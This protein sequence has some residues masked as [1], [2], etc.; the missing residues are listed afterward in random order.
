MFGVLAL[1]LDYINASE[2]VEAANAWMVAKEE[3][4]GHLLVKNGVLNEEDRDFLELVLEKHVAKSGSIDQSLTELS[5]PKTNPIDMSWSINDTPDTSIDPG[6]TRYLSAEETASEPRYISLRPLAKGG[7][8]QVLIARDPELEREVALKEMLGGRVWSDD[9]KARFVAEAKITGGLEHPGIVPVYGLGVFSDGRP[10]YA[11]RLIRGESLRAAITDFHRRPTDEKKMHT[12]VHSFRKLI[13]SL[14]DACYAVAY[15]HNRGVI[16]RDLKPS[17]IMV[18]KFGETLVVDW[19]LAKPAGTSTRPATFYSE[20]PMEDV[21][22][23]DSAP[24]MMGSVLGTPSYM[25]PEQAEGRLDLMDQRTDVFSLGATLYVIL[26]NKLPYSS[27]SRE[28]LMA[29]A[30]S[31]KFARPRDLESKIPK[32]LEAVCL[33]AMSK[34]PS[35]RYNSAVELAEELDRWIA[36][37]PVSAIKEPLIHR[38]FRWARRN[39]ALVSG[40]A[41]LITVS[42]IAM[43]IANWAIGV[44]RDIARKQRDTAN[45]LRTIADAAKEA[46]EKDRKVAESLRAKAE[47]ATLIAQR[48]SSVSIDILDT[49]VKRLADD[50][51]SEVPQL[52]QERIAMVDLAVDRYSKLLKESPD[53]LR[54]KSD[55]VQILVRSGNL[56]RMTGRHKKAETQIK[57]AIEI[58]DSLPAEIDDDSRAGLLS[59]SLFSLTSVTSSKRGATAAAALCERNLAIAR[60]RVKASPKSLMAKIGL[61]KVLL[62]HGDLA[63]ET[64]QNLE[65]RSNAQEAAEHL[66]NLLKQLDKQFVI[67]LFYIYAH[68]L[69]AKAYLAESSFEEARSV[70]EKAVSLGQAASTKFPN[71]NNVTDFVEQARIEQGKYLL[72]TGDVEKGTKTLLS[73]LEVYRKLA[74]AFPD[75][76]SYRRVQAELNA[77]LGANAFASGMRTKASK[78]AKASLNLIDQLSLGEDSIAEYLPIRIESLAVLVLTAD[79]DVKSYQSSFSVARQS[80]LKINAKHPLLKSGL[81][82]K[83]LPE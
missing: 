68:T 18:G 57:R 51:W 17:N 40:L 32:A 14:I 47:Q 21:R 6:E 81:L 22:S 2:L 45:E 30:R 69:E 50:K 72:L 62:Q 3:S 28:D 52:E 34:K 19:G 76:T 23:G 20:A 15:A 56:Y 44:Q 55:V 13:R 80:L 73:S 10:Y 27:N 61:I 59:D 54:L 75:T 74:V 65:A 39:Q 16:H 38:A 26:T 64:C 9:A 71:N 67:H 83:A 60:R 66:A 43:A 36:G 35:D 37:Y 41:V 8:G 53:N 42:L 24:T 77:T 49:F 7:L 12:E 4:I 25:S 31:G 70:I 29:A 11:M 46:A 78:F 1:Q 33:K 58:I 48:N 5:S 82:E 63:I 79:D